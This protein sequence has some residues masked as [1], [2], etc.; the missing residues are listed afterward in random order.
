MSQPFFVMAYEQGEGGKQGKLLTSTEDG[1][2]E[3]MLIGVNGPNVDARIDA[4]EKMAIAQLAVEQKY[5]PKKDNVPIVL[6]L[7]F[8]TPAE[9]KK[10][11]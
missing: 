11:K 6:L 2:P 5:D 10:S 3:P 7:P 1:K 4:V 8:L 9:L